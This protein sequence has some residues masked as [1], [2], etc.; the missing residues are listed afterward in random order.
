MALHRNAE[1]GE[2]FAM[3]FAPAANIVVPPIEELVLQR[4]DMLLIDK[5]VS[6]GA[7]CIE[8]AACLGPDHPLADEQ[9]IPCWV[10]IELMAQTVLAFLG[11]ELRAKG[12]APRIGLLLGTRNYE[13]QVPHF[14]AGRELRILATVAWRDDEGVGVF[15]CSVRQAGQGE[16][17]LARANVKG[18]APRDIATWLRT[19]IDG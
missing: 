11:L 9:G 10:G 12:E 6:C 19:A 14:P 3:A 8:V 2:N 4:G 15:D 16:R 13:A 17:E 7:E 1:V 18:F 5:V